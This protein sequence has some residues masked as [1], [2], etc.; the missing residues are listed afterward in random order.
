MSSELQLDVC[1]RSCCGGDIWWTHTKERQAWCYL[2]VKRCDPRLS[3]LSVV[4]TIKALYKYTSFLFLS[5]HLRNCWA[6]VL[7]RVCM[8]L[9]PAR[10]GYRLFVW[11]VCQSV[12]NELLLQGNKWTGY[13]II[14]AGS[15]LYGTVCFHTP[16]VMVIYYYNHWS[17]SYG[18]AKQAAHGAGKSRD[19]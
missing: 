17:H 5:F 9:C 1:C 2:Q 11:S 19:F 16:E 12:R 4:A 8:A 13:H 6:L 18:N 3:A 15:S 10:Y 7:L 14:K